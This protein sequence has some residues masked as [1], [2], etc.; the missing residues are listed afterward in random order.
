MQ[1]ILQS[2]AREENSHII[3]Y[4][5][6]KITAKIKRLAADLGT[7]WTIGWKSACCTVNAIDGWRTA[8]NVKILLLSGDH[9]AETVMSSEK[10]VYKRHEHILGKVD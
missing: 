9:V 6:C 5:F 7:K 1:F 4:R 8:W 10:L 2:V 3:F